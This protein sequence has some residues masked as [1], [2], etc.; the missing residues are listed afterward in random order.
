MTLS[1]IV[2]DCMIIEEREVYRMFELVVVWSDGSKSVY[3][4][5]SDD[6]AYAA[7][8]RMRFALGYQVAWFGTRRKV[9]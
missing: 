3:E 7:G 6:D 9:S 4:Y 2:F 1:V 8:E 5:A